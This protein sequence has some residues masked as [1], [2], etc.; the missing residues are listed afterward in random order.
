M[1]KKIK[2]QPLGDRVLVKLSEKETKTSSGIYLSEAEDKGMK[3]G[4]VLSVGGGKIVDGKVE[5]VTSV[6]K[7]DVV[8]F[9][10]GDEIK[11][12]GEEYFLVKESEISAIINN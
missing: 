6:K 10:W 11:V 5:P 8:L 12:D 4:E 9:Q 7:G 3:E 1:S 2:V